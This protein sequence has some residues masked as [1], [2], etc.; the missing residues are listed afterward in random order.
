MLLIT[1]HYFTVIVISTTCFPSALATYTFALF[2]LAFFFTLIF[3]LLF[4][5]ST[6]VSELR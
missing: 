5:V 1:S 2:P 3:Q 4:T 6:D